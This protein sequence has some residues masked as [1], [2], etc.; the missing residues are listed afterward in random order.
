[1]TA[2]FPTLTAQAQCIWPLGAT[3]GEGAT[4][5]VREQSLYFVDILG[6]RLHRYRPADGQC[7]SWSFE[8][9]ITALA[10]RREYAGLLVSLRQDLALFDP[11][12]G[13]LLRLHRP[14][15]ERPNNRLN[16]GKCDAAG[17][18]WIGST[19]FQCA[20][21][22]GALYRYHE[23]RCERMRDDIHISNG[24]V[25]SADGTQMFLNETGALRTWRHAFDPHT[26]ELGPAELWLQHDEADGAPDGMVTDSAGCI[27]IAR[28]GGS[29]ITR[30]DGT[31]ALVGQVTLPTQFITSACFGGKDLRTLYIT[32]AR[33]D[34]TPEQLKDQPLAGGLFAVDLEIDGPQAATFSG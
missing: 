14:E 4:W 1:M 6:R 30:H 11:E 28:W 21:A 34:L 27:W 24:P 8:E 3:L 5:S 18:W 12:T 7:R 13:D 33:G 25:W 2:P 17:R 23:G 20:A 26:G 9:E 16:D 10:E 32:S 31:G 29:K 19:D 22:T 15:P